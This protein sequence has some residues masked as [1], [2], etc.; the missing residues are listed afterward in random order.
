LSRCDCRAR[1]EALEEGL[2]GDWI[3]S[4]VESHTMLRL[5]PCVNDTLKIWAV[6]PLGTAIVG[7][8]ESSLI[9]LVKSQAEAAYIMCPSLGVKCRNQGVP[10]AV[11]INERLFFCETF[12]I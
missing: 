8:S 5:G 3:G 10:Y 2:E 11:W 12:G 9:C 4:V 1:R 7:N 6:I